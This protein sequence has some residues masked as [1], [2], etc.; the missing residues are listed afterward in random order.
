MAGSH[1]RLQRLVGLW[2]QYGRAI[3]LVGTLT[4][5]GLWEHVREA[6]LGVVAVVRLH[7]GTLPS[8]CMWVDVG[9][10]GGLPGLVVA[11]VTD[12]E[13]VLIEPRQRRAAFLELGLAS[14]GRGGGQ[15]IRAR[16]GDSTWNK[17]VVS[18]RETRHRTPYFILSQRAVFSAKKWLEEA[19]RASFSRGLVLCHV[20]S[21]TQQVGEK[22]PSAVAEDSRWAVLAFEAGS[23]VESGG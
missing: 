5:D 7:E 6:L 23:H 14:V 13:V 16:W 19:R 3:N 11:A 2:R 10:G 22:K 4:P 17:V 1:D 9:S 21:G 20:E 18:G 12:W 15:V 8:G